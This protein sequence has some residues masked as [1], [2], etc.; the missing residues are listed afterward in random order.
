MA[1]RFEEFLEAV[2]DSVEGQAKRKNYTKNDVNGEN[3]L[4]EVG[5]LL[6][7]E[8][9]HGIGE[10]VYKCAE[11]LKNPREVLLIKIAG[12]AGVL[13]MRHHGSLEEE[14]KRYFESVKEPEGEPIAYASDKTMAEYRPWTDAA[15]EALNSQQFDKFVAAVPPPFN[16]GE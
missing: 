16:S 13:W 8:P 1:K 6:E 15:I 14:T 4:S 10:I 12:W 5:R 2:R 7:F 11:Y 3:Q 9:Q